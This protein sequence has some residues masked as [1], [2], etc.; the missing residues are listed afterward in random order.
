MLL[1]A[2]PSPSITL[3]VRRAVAFAA[4]TECRWPDPRCTSPSVRSIGGQLLRV[5]LARQVGR[6]LHEVGIA[7]IAGTV[8]VGPAAWP[9]P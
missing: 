8:A 5:V 1:T 6:H 9:R 3:K 2:M 4:S 7:E